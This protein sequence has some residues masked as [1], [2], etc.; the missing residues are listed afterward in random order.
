MSFSTVDIQNA[1]FEVKTIITSAQMVKMNSILAQI[2]DR[3]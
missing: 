3:A 2:N 1:K